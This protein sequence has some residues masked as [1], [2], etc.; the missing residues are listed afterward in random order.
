MGKKWKIPTSVTIEKEDLDKIDELRNG[1]PRAKIFQIMIKL[2]L[3][4]KELTK[5]VFEDIKY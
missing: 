4:N 2:I 5:E 3:K 1:I